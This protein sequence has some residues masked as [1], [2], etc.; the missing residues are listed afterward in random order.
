[1]GLPGILARSIG[2]NIE[3]IYAGN[4]KGVLADVDLLQQMTEASRKCVGEFVKERTGA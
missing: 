1:M 4:N 2:R 3:Q